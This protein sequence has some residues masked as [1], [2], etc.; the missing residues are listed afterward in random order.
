MKLRV[1]SIL[2]VLAELPF[3]LSYFVTNQIIVTLQSVLT[4]ENE[5]KKLI[6]KEK[7]QVRIAQEA[8]QKAMKVYIE[9]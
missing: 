9:K 7:D 8:H 4:I 2:N 5:M 1:W 6:Q 3:D